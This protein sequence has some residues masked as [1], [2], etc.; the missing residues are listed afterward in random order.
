MKFKTI[1]ILLMLICPITAL[2]STIT[3]GPIGCNYTHIWEAL[4][5]ANPGDVIEVENG[6][7]YENLI[8]DKPII[9]RGNNTIIDASSLRSPIELISDGITLEGLT[10]VN[11]GDEDNDAGIR[12]RSCNNSI[13]NNNICFNNYG[14]YLEMSAGNVISGNSIHSNYNDGIYLLVS[15]NNTI[16]SNTIEYNTISY[17]SAYDMLMRVIVYPAGILLEESSNNNTINSNIIA[18]NDGCGIKI[19]E[20]NANYITNNYLEE[21]YIGIHINS[22]SYP[23]YIAGNHLLNNVEYNARDEYLKGGNQNQW[24]VKSDN[25]TIGNEYGDFNEPSEGCRDSDEDGI[26]DF[27]YEIPGGNAIDKFPMTT[28]KDSCLED[29]TIIGSWQD[30]VGNKV[31]WPIN[32]TIPSNITALGVRLTWDDPNSD[33]ALLL[34]NETGY[35]ADVSYNHNMEENVKA[36]NPAHGI[37]HVI[38]YGYHVQE[39]EAQEFDLEARVV[40]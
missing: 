3:V 14:I 8:I 38:V 32:I 16:D 2:A 36:N 28:Y 23:N 31:I 40:E 9:I 21:N 7:Y 37:W 19:W 33:L 35:P 30:S 10:I 26:C 24:Y 22:N 29:G 11:S 25:L 13:I 17:H 20:S 12:V 15:D 34:F 4:D 39:G 1:L 5:V 6:T 27:A 18:N